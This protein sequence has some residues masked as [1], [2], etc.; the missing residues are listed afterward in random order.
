[1]VKGKI[2]NTEGR[3][4]MGR[5]GK[6]TLEA[7]Y[8][9]SVDGQN[10]GLAD[11][12][13]SNEGRKRTGATVAHVVMWGPLGLFAK[14]RAASVILD[15]EFDL[16]IDN[17]TNIDLSKS[18]ASDVDTRNIKPLDVSFVKYGKKINFAKGKLGKDFK[19]NLNLPKDFNL[20]SNDIKITT[21]LN[22]KLPHP[23]T[24]KTVN[25]NKKSNTF[26]AIIDFKE[27]LKYI[28]EGTVDV[29]VSVDVDQN[30]VLVGN[31]DLTTKWKT[32]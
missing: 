14:G 5:A 13:I 23:V 6:L 11:D 9:E 28:A 26:T 21:V 19:L 20:N 1:M 7:R 32:R 15:S 27:M 10:V 30:S 3:K 4:S 29:V 8:V 18:I 12:P 22:H 25:W 16:E 24:A 2:T 17:D 31:T